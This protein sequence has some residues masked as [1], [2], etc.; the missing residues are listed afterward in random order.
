MPADITILILTMNE[1]EN[2]PK[3]LESVRGFARRVVVVDSGSSD[4]TR[5]IALEAGADVYENTWVNYATQFNWGPRQHQYRYH[6]DLP[7]GC[8]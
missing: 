4:R 5:E 7:P 2:L 6:L 1:E 8:G 3:A